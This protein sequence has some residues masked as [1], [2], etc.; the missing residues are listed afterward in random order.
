MKQRYDAFYRLVKDFFI[1]Y[2][3][4]ILDESYYNYFNVGKGYW[5]YTISDIYNINFDNANM[6]Y[7]PICDGDAFDDDTAKTICDY[8]PEKTFIVIFSIIIKGITVHKKLEI[9]KNGHIL[10]E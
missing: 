8:D 2:A 5:L 6:V 1:Q 4:E 3:Q 10:D 7:Y 9:D